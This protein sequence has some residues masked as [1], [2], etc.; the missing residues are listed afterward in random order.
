MDFAGPNHVWLNVYEGD[1]PF[2][3]RN[4]TFLILAGQ[5]FQDSEIIAML[6]KVKLLQQR[7]SELCVLGLHTGSS[8]SF[9]ADRDHVIDLIMKEYITFPILLSNKNFAEMENGA[10]YIMF[11]DS[12]NPLVQHE[13]DLDIG[14]L[15]AV[16]EEMQV[17][18][19][20]NPGDGNSSMACLKSTWTKLADAVKEPYTVSPI[21]NLLLYFPGCISADINGSR[22]FF[23][24]SNHHRIIISDGNGSILDCIG[25]SPGFEDGDFE[26]AKL[27]RPG[28][29]FYDD[30]ED[31]L[32]FVDSENH[33]VRRADLERRVLETLYPSSSATVEKESLWTKIASKLGFGIAAVEAKSEEFDP[34]SLVFPWHLLK[35]EEEDHCLII[36]RS[37]ETLWV[38]NLTTGE[39]K[40]VIKGFQKIRDTCGNLIT[41]KLSLLKEMPSDWLEQQAGTYLS[42]KDTL[43]A[44]LIS[45]LTAFN[46]HV[47]ACDT[48]AQKVVKMNRETRA[49]SMFQLVNYRILGL[50]YWCSFPLERIYS[51][52][53]THELWTDHLQ[54]FNQLPGRTD[55]DIKVDIPID[56]ELVEPL[57]EG[58]IW[59]QAR[60]AAT[61]VSGTNAELES[62]E[63]VGVAQKWY[64]ELDNLAFSSA[65]ESET[66]VEDDDSTTA[67]TRNFEDDKV[68]IHCAVNT[69]PGLSEVIIY[70][71]LYL[72]LR[73]DANVDE[74]DNQDK[75]AARIADILKWGSHG[76]TTRDSCIQLL[77]RSGKDLRDLVFVKP[78]HFRIR[79]ECPNHPKAPDNTKD[80][81]LTNSTV[82]V[83]VSL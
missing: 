16:V 23:S 8:A 14:T 5:F 58:C 49:C 30:T 70:A 9:A 27:L 40:D 78:L 22:L 63:K 57:H 43:Y 32:Y 69:S 6:E 3:K 31:C 34:Q 67:D 52:S 76:L 73:R 79:I 4:G 33:A 82:G 56:T 77:S 75:H 20:Q 38:M 28:A 36:N 83:H 51:L 24:D 45:S 65:A 12:E 48:T 21:Q 18:Q 35:S 53:P 37:F 11:R 19:K 54:H 55:I 61:E 47:F 80:I 26:C 71:P 44:T 42:S 46:G 15:Y 72:R 7:F 81:I 2:L 25:S 1:K 50:P 39:I 68:R 66:I 10:C 13:K 29:S 59:R 64:D 41:D 74:E 62:S 17:L 60:G